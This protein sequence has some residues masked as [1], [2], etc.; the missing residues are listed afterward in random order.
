MGDSIYAIVVEELGLIGGIAL[1]GLYLMLFWCLL[2]IAG[3]TDDPFARLFT[4]GMG[5][6]IIMQAFINIA[7]ISG[8]I[9]LTGVPLPFVSYGSSSLISILTGLGIVRNIARKAT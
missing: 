4:L 6:W 3:A 9:P 5:V 8:L 2:S 7:A 1:I